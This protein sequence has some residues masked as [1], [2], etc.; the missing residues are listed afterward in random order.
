MLVS[1][2]MKG[3]PVVA[4][5][6]ALA[7]AGC[8]SAD[9]SQYPSLA[10]RAVEMRSPVVDAAPTG[11]AVPAPASASVAQAADALGRDADGGNTAFLAE[12]ARGRDAVV[13]GRGAP[14]DT[15]LW[16]MAQVALSRM[17]AARGPTMVALAELDRL[18]L[19]RRDADDTAAADMLGAVQARVAA[20]ADAQQRAMDALLR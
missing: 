2:H 4:V 17:E 7:L 8:A 5:L 13:A 20:M 16:S 6:A 14:A 10:R 18:T 12:L 1:R 3:I 9:M 15:E 19:E 11:T